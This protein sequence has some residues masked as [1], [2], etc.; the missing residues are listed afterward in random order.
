MS[1]AQEKENIRLIQNKKAG[2]L[3]HVNLFWSSL[4]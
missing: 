3:L 1:R 2:G 4:L